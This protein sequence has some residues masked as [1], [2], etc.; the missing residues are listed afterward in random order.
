M[1]WA[2]TVPG[3]AVLLAGPDPPPGFLLRTMPAPGPARLGGGPDHGVVRDGCTRS[4]RVP[5]L[6]CWQPT[7]RAGPP[8]PS[9]RH[10]SP[11]LPPPP[12]PVQQPNRPGGLALRRSTP[13]PEMPAPIVRPICI[14]PDG[15]AVSVWVLRSWAGARWWCLD[16]HENKSPTWISLWE[17]T[18]T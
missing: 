8:W 11:P 3:H 18:E 17:K 7:G 12:R 16:T 10:L 1:W 4:G 13:L 6:C 9:P 15:R 14:C 2:Q 5:P